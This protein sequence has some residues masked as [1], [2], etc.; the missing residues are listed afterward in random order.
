MFLSLSEIYNALNLLTI[1]I[2]Y[3]DYD[4]FFFIFGAILLY[5]IDFLGL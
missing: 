3:S 4:S 5:G 1:D 2:S